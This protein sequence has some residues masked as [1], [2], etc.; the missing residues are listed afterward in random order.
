MAI[1][2]G[3]STLVATG[4]CGLMLTSLLKRVS[5]QPR[6][7]FEPRPIQ[8]R[9]FSGDCDVLVYDSL[10]FNSGAKLCAH[11]FGTTAHRQLQSFPLLGPFKTRFCFT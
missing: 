1:Q 7:F 6:R 4:A 11:V 9:R 8:K 5:T 2:C 10:K 3:F